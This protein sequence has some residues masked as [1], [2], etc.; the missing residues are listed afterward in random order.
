MAEL[1][2]GDGPPGRADPKGEVAHLVV[3]QTDVEGWE[4]VF[5][6]FFG[7]YAAHPGPSVG[8]RPP[9]QDALAVHVFDAEAV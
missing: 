8:F 2:A 4:V 1:E 5:G 7:G 9:G 3:L 6:Q